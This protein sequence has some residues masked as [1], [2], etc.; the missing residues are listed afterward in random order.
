MRSII[1]KEQYIDPSP[2][3]I[4]SSN[5]SIQFEQA[6]N[7]IISNAY[8]IK[9]GPILDIGCGTGEFTTFLA[10]LFSQFVMGV[11]ISLE[12]I[13]FASS[14]YGRQ[15]IKFVIADATQ[16]DK[17]VEIKSRKFETVVSF[18]ALHHIPITPQDANNGECRI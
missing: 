12:R 14:T 9:K 6:K 15:N 16:L 13:K 3:N 5:N 7:F 11:D 8:L 1:Q 4:Y 18:N 2:A 10:D 17:Q